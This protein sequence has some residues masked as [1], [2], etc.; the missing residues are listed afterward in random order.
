M[1]QEKISLLV[2]DAETNR[3]LGVTQTG[4]LRTVCAGQPPLPGL[5]ALVRAA[6]GRLFAACA[7]THEIICLAPDGQHLKTFS[8][9]SLQAPG[10][11]D[12]DVEGNLYVTSRQGKALVKFNQ[13]GQVVAQREISQPKAV[14]LSRHSSQQRF[15]GVT[16][17][18]SDTILI[19]AAADLTPVASQDLGASMAG[20]LNS[21]FIAPQLVYMTD[22]VRHE[23]LT[24]AD[25]TRAFHREA[26]YHAGQEPGALAEGPAGVFVCCTG[27]GDIW[28]QRQ[29]AAPF[30]PFTKHRI[31]HPVA[32]VWLD[33]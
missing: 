26:V 32:A 2:A 27:S 3:I 33:E 22:P 31:G 6:D 25:H 5:S 9:P 7:A 11:L 17:T 20:M 8:A 18:G 1:S 30:E 10:S 4:E 21:E 15:V 12:L 28:V 23:I 13:A 29:S 14:F 16:Q 19:F 24:F